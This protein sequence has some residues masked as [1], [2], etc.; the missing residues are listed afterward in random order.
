ML[1]YGFLLYATGSSKIKKP[2][3]LIVHTNG[4]LVQ[5]RRDDGDGRGGGG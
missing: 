2:T 3:I 1:C 4:G 5:G